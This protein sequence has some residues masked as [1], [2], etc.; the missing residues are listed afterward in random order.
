M[1]RLANQWKFHRGQWE[2]VDYRW[3]EEGDGC[4]EED[5]LALGYRFVAALA[6]ELECEQALE[7]FVYTNSSP[8]PR[9]FGGAEYL[10][11]L[12]M[13]CAVYH[14]FAP[15][16]G[17]FLEVMTRVEPLVRASI[18]TEQLV[19]LQ[20]LRDELRQVLNELER[21]AEGG[22]WKTK[23]PR[24]AT[25]EQAAWLAARLGAPPMVTP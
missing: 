19:R 23:E 12:V 6:T 17:D 7:A 5:L 20:E 13:D 8:N 22:G 11:Q 1:E 2:A 16:F 9:R 10:V 3:P 21:F 24:P 25:G 14:L 15:T 4:G 18:R